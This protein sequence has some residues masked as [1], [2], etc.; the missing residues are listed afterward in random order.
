MTCIVSIVTLYY[1]K[2]HVLLPVI[3]IFFL[4]S[5]SHHNHTQRGTI[6][7]VVSMANSTKQANK[8]KPNS[9]ANTNENLTS[10]GFN[11]R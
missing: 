7:V 1:I 10:P 6:P 2:L 4:I 8:L 5:V 9:N 11:S 3:I